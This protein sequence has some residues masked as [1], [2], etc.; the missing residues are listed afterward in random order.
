MIYQSEDLSEI[1]LTG[2]KFHF[3]ASKYQIVKQAREFTFSLLLLGLISFLFW[4]AA[5]STSYVE[6]AIDSVVLGL[7]SAQ[8][9][10]LFY[11]CLHVSAFKKNT[12]IR[13][14]VAQLVDFT[15]GLI[16]VV[17]TKD[18]LARENSFFPRAEFNISQ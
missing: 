5:L 11:D 6:V 1:D 17:L 12:K 4:R 15:Y 3:V 9:V 16:T 18:D 2:V 8:A 7:C 10:L 13:S 14:S